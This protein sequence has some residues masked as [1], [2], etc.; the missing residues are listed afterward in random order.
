MGKNLLQ[1][2]HSIA[3]LKINKIQDKDK[4]K[5]IGMF[6]SKVK[7]LCEEKLSR[8]YKINRRESLEAS[9]KRRCLQ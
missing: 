1:I 9:D 7:K 5:K 6:L 8:L 4:I 2:V 3:M